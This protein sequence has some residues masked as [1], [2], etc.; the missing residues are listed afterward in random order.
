MCQDLLASQIQRKQ[1][2]LAAQ[3]DAVESEPAQESQEEIVYEEPQVEDALM[4]TA[5]D[6]VTRQTR[7]EQTMPVEHAPSE[8]TVAVEIVE[9]SEAPAVEEPVE[10]LTDAQSL[11]EEIS[12]EPAIPI[13]NAAQDQLSVEEPST[14]YED[15]PPVAQ[16]EPAWAEEV[17]QSDAA[18]AVEVITPETFEAVQVEQVS[19]DPVPIQEPVPETA[20]V[21]Q[22][23]AEHQVEEQVPVSL[24]QPEPAPEQSTE[25]PQVI[26]TESPQE[27]KESQPVDEP[28][29]VAKEAFLVEPAEQM[30]A[31]ATTESPSVVNNLEETDRLVD[32]VN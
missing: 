23:I 14:Y 29:Q 20:P 10:Q 2:E 17:A 16:E 26:S 28:V 4:E 25:S 9:Q 11:A 24:S 13:E 30:A 22:P 19:V 1:D 15:Q 7:D 32:Q 18:P 27:P 12:E 31:P 6:D 5:E 8:P 3:Q 21:V